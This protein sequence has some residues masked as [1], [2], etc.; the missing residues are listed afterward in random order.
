MLLAALLFLGGEARG[1]RL[2]KQ[3]KQKCLDFLLHCWRKNRPCWRE[4]W[5]LKE[6]GL[7]AAVFAVFSHRH[8]LVVTNQDADFLSHPHEQL[9]P[10]I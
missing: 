3:M 9:A 1:A 6:G 8:L 4:L 2:A 5:W 10:R 7:G